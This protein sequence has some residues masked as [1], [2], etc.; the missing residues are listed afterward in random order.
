MAGTNTWVLQLD[1]L[2]HPDLAT[3]LLPHLTGLKLHLEVCSSAAS[4]RQREGHAA[5]LLP[6]AGTSKEPVTVSDLLP[7]TPCWWPP[8]GWL[9]AV[10]QLAVTT[11][12]PPQALKAPQPLPSYTLAQHKINKTKFIYLKI[13]IFPHCYS[14]VNNFSSVQPLPHWPLGAQWVE[15]RPQD[16]PGEPLSGRGAS[17]P[18][19]DARPGGRRSRD[20]R[21][22]G[23]KKGRRKRN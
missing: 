2:T 15:L 5:T 22:T 19:N 11:V 13:Y 8:G 16:P 21:R 3:P 14:A 17:N 10:H 9:G 1:T 7:Q 12:R 20:R 6:P 23:W 18:E 4:G